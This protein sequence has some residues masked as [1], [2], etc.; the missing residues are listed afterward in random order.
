AHGGAK[1][2]SK[3][4]AFRLHHKL[5][6]PINT[7]QIKSTAPVSKHNNPDP[8]PSMVSRRGRTEKP[9]EK[10]LSQSNELSFSEDTLRRIGIFV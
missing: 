5:Y 3:P 6:Y 7:R 10:I 1:I 2:A 9:L 4:V 8:S